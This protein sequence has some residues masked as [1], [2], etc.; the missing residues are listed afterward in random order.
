MPTESADLT[1]AGC[2]AAVYREHLDEGIAARV[3][4]KLL[5]NFCLAEQ[6]GDAPAP[7]PPDGPAVPSGVRPKHVFRRPL[8]PNAAAATRCKT[9]HCKLAIGALDHLDDQINEW[10]DS[11]PEV[12]IKFATT[13][14]GVVEGKHND[15]HYLI[16]LFY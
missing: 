16:T 7:P 6:R 8:S 5:C 10:V 13:T 4:G 11:N 2:G 1:C 14:V 12:Q 9:F 3:A 15:P